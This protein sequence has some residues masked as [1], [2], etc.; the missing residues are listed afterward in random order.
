VSQ[1]DGTSGGVI[2]YDRG[3]AMNAFEKNG[4]ELRGEVDELW[5]ILLAAATSQEAQSTTCVLDALDECREKD[6]QMVIQL[7]SEFYTHSL[8]HGSGRN[9]LKFLVTSR[10]YDDIQSGFQ[11]IPPDLPVIR[12]L[13]EEEN[14]EI[15][16]EIDL[17]VRQRVA[18]M[19]R[20]HG[21]NH[22]MTEVI[23]QRLLGME[24]RT[25]L[26]LH[27]AMKII[28]DAFNDSLRPDMESLEP[29][30]LPS[31]V[32]EAYEKILGK[33][34]SKNKK[35][36]KTIFHIIVV[37]RRPL[38]TSEMAVA[39]GI[40]TNEEAQS[41]KDFRIDP[42][43]LERR[44]RSWCGLF[45]FINH[46]RIY[47]IHQTARAFLIKAN[48]QDKNDFWKHCL[49]PKESE[50]IMARICIDYLSLREFDRP[51]SIKR[52]RIEVL[53]QST[54]RLEIT[55][56]EMADVYDV[57]SFLTYSAEHWAAHFRSVTI[58]MD[59]KLSTKIDRLYL[60]EHD[61][62]QLWFSLL[63]KAQRPYE[64]QPEMNNVRLAA[65]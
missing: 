49:E 9:Y 55:D 4:E 46:S 56:E 31:T 64:V 38:T 21:L 37:A 53:R 24:N 28:G 39:L 40:A 10:P 23:E 8:S 11:A 47:L 13:G 36:V 45:V 14:D 65:F 15:H 63:W 43:R 29:H 1:P 60:V 30:Q 7:L 48:S 35:V 16:K 17:V 61:R 26:W 44:I 33:I 54:T 18:D 32:E 59:E 51:P 22:Q 42:N 41:F 12:L 34:T 6:R 20:S 52:E 57:K 2:Q 27:L 62:F 5:R 3:Y 50:E 19:A 58:A 25:Y